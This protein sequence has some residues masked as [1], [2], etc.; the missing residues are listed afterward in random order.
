M[1]ILLPIALIC[2]HALSVQAQRKQLHY[3]PAKVTLTGKV[4]L[5]TFFGPPGYG[6][7]PKTDS[8]ETQYI[9]IL[10]TPIDVIGVN[11]DNYFPYDRQT[12][13][14]VKQITLVIDDFK[15]TPERTFLHKHVMLEGTLVHAHTGHHHTKVLL[16]ISS[17]R[18]AKQG[19]RS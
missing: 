7:N 14:R 5:R 6:E 16:E 8:K 12:E 19:R 9:L 3:A 11:D 10:D 17:I 1:K 18:P 4:I 15:A 2:A 13:R